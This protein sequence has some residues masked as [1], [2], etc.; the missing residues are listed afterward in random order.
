MPDFHIVSGCRFSLCYALTSRHVAQQYD[1]IPGPMWLPLF[2]VDFEVLL[3][4][5]NE[6]RQH[7]PQSI[8]KK[9]PNHSIS[10]QTQDEPIR[11]YCCT[12]GVIGSEKQSHK[13]K[14]SRQ[15]RWQ[16]CFL[17]VD[18]SQDKF[19]KIR[20]YCESFQPGIET[21][22]GTVC[23]STLRQEERHTSA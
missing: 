17:T 10:F 3:L 14:F 6:S 5:A 11:S 19:Y 15:G 8:K 22:R 23:C 1:S 13:D 21:K 18:L 7:N 4:V 2:H 20:F 16:E 12:Y 9:T